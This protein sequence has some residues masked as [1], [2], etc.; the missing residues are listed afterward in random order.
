MDFGMPYLLE[1]KS[2]RQCAELCHE[3]GLAFVELNANFPACQMSR[4]DADE[5]RVLAG[6]FGLYYTF[7]VEE[8]CDPFTFNP[9]VRAAWLD[10]V[11]QALHLARQLDMPVVNMHFPRG[12]YITLPDRKTF[13]YD[14]YEDEFYAALLDFRT[15]CE[16]ALHGCRTRVAIEN[17][18]GWKPHELRAVEFMLESP[19]FGLTLDIGHSHGV[20]DVDE[21]FFHAHSG[22]LI[23]MHGHDALGRRNHLALGD[24][25]IDLRARFAWARR[26]HARVVL[27][28]KTIAALRTSVA[29][30]PQILAENP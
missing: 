25:E 1:M 8:E 16:E 15:L 10:T 28:T 6:E 7:H 22:C 5:L 30:L 26:N 27:E 11:R 23:H 18:S 21:P 9:A 29:R 24:G 3:L 12:V 14:Q 19:V 20:E 4:M 2:I 17:T 13:L